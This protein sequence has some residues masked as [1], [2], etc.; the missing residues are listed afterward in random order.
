MKEAIIKLKEG[1][2]KP[3]RQRHPW[4]F[5]GAIESSTGGEDGGPA[6]IIAADGRFLAHGYINR[7]SQITARALS[8][9]EDEQIDES[10]WRRRLERSISARAAVNET[11]L[12]L[13]FSESDGLPGL[14]VD[15]YGDWLVMQ[16][17]TL[18]IDRL[19]KPLAAMLLEL[20]GARGVWERSDM[21]VRRKEGLEQVT[22]LLAGEAPPERIQITERA[23]DGRLLNFLVNPRD[24][25]KTGFYLDQRENRRRAARWCA[26]GELLNVFSYTGAFGVHALAAGARRVVHLDSSGDALAGARRHCELNGF[27]VDEQDFIAADAF[28]TLRRMH[29]EQQ[30]FDTIVL[31]P[32][33]LA[34]AA[35]HLDRATRAYKDINMSAM[36]L[37]RPGGTLITF[38]CS[39]LISPDLFQKI[40]FGAA[41]DVG[42]DG[43][44]LERLTQ[45]PDHPVLLTYPESEYLKGLVIRVDE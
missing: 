29:G 13:V 10:F 38:S 25:H 39:G 14:I 21:E 23:A 37:L 43:R 3:V 15:R 2:E 32:P 12:R 1:R 31:D 7:R 35:S 11:A 42:R 40:L 36:A 26:G 45:S 24:G 30:R 33:R 20:T 6:R 16:V 4:I 27:A 9:V 5:S 8:W 44:I 28:E 17:M 22:G 34:P 18:G 19:K 41:L